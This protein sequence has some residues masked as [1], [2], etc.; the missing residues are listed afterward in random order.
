MEYLGLVIDQKLTPNSRSFSKLQMYGC[1]GSNVQLQRFRGRNESMFWTI[2]GESND[3][4]GETVT[5][6]THKL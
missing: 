5:E 3:V 6:W 4:K 2:S 1:R